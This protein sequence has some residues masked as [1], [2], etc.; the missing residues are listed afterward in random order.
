MQAF[1]YPLKSRFAGAW[2]PDLRA[3]RSDEA[4]Q[5]Y[6]ALLMDPGLAY[7]APQWRQDADLPARGFRRARAALIRDGLLSASGTLIA[8]PATAYLSAAMNSAVRRIELAWA[9]YGPQT[10]RDLARLTGIGY[11]SPDLRRVPFGPAPDARLAQD[12][13]GRSCQRNGAWARNRL[14][15]AG[16]GTVLAWMPVWSRFRRELRKGNAWL[17]HTLRQRNLPHLDCV[18]IWV[19]EPIQLPLF[20]V[21]VAAGAV[22]KVTPSGQKSDSGAVRKVTPSGQKSDAF[23]PH[24]NRKVNGGRVKGSESAGESAGADEGVRDGRD[25]APA[26]NVHLGRFTESFLRNMAPAERLRYLTSDAIGLDRPRA[27]AKLMEMGLDH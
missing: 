17:V 20:E 11:N 7:D 9:L 6:W 25:S 18:P 8:L 12:W 19:F 14:Q 10:R 27:I 4:W 1:S 3:L 15:E 23:A 2:D 21:S 13:L 26:S 22:R 16:T 24:V 5:A